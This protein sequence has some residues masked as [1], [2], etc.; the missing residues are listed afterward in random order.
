MV[1]QGMEREEKTAEERVEEI[2]EGQDKQRRI[3]QEKEGVQG[4]V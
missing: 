4:V 3:C 1:R 2:E